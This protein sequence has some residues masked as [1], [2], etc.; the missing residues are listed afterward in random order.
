MAND[1][2]I[3]RKI[4]SELERTAEILLRYNIVQDVGPL[5]A[6]AASCLSYN[7]ENCWAYQLERLLFRNLGDFKKLPSR[8]ED[9]YLE[10]SVYV[11][12]LCKPEEGGDPLLNL[13][14]DIII[15]GQILLP[16]NENGSANKTLTSAW[17]LDR[18]IFNEDNNLPEYFHPHYHFQYGGK[19][20][21]SIED[22]NDGLLPYGIALFTDSPRI[23]HPPMEALLGI[24]FVLTNFM[25]KKSIAFRIEDGGYHNLL[26]SK[27]EQIWKPYIESLSRSW[28]NVRADDPWQPTK[29][30]PQLFPK[31]Y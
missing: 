11:S 19:N 14:M 28:Q 6:A 13:G 21:K 9:I 20:L 30:W 29:I 15:R 12:G 25:S 27:Q 16:N 31:R 8:V 24:D 18:H 26:Q 5:Y 17:H 22:N 3:R 1:D 2:S 10:L 4:A 23:A 7:R